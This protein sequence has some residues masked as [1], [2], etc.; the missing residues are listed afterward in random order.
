MS[1]KITLDE[2]FKTDKAVIHCDTEV[3][4]I[5]LLTAFDKMGKTWHSGDSYINDI[6]WKNYT[7]ET[8]YCN[9]GC[10]G[11]INYYRTNNYTIFE[12]EDI[13]FKKENG[14]M[15][16][17]NNNLIKSVTLNDKKKVTTVV[18]TDNDV[19]MVKCGDNDEYSAEM[20]IVY[21]IALKYSGLSKTQFKKMIDGLIDKK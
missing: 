7:T 10:Y 15:N 6:K 12:F 14:K 8:A 4:A 20:G 3:K 5:I 11:R 16:K 17:S 13:I 1:R 19:K 18:F 21:C 2:F 9:N